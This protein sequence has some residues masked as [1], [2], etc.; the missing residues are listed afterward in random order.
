MKQIDGAKATWALESKSTATAT[1]NPGDLFGSTAY[2]RVTPV[3]PA[4][5]GNYTL[6]P[7]DS[8]QTCPNVATETAHV[9]P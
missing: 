5:T 1:P 2:I 3:C 8:V 6:V 9:Q 7:V 4:G